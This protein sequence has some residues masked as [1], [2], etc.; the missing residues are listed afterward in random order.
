MSSPTFAVPPAPG[1]DNVSPVTASQDPASHLTHAALNGTT[2][3]PVAGDSFGAAYVTKAYELLARQPLREAL[4]F[5]QFATVRLANQTHRGAVVQVSLVPDLDDDPATTLL[6]EDYDVLPTPLKSR[7]GETRLKEYG[8]VITTTD[9][10]SA[11][12]MIPVDP[13]AAERLGRNAGAV[14]DRLAL[15]ALTGPAV[16]S[17]APTAASALTAPEEVAN[18]AG[19][20]TET[21]IKVSETFQASNVMPFSGGYYAAIISP[22]MASA[23]RKEAAAVGWRYWQAE[24]GNAPGGEIGTGGISTY[25]GFRFFVSNRVTDDAIFFGQ[26]ALLKTFPAA[27]GFGPYPQVVVSPIV[28]RLRRF[29]S[30]GWKW[31]GGYERFVHEAVL[32]G[33]GFG[34]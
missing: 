13:I 34:A 16:L 8:K 11:T 32:V 25:E 17:A 2:G 28:D 27:P 4:I 21:L 33:T 22:A 5:D 10:L 19:K 26:D 3:L 23:I 14:L 12:S 30:I 9:L 6:Q 18:V 1:S 20:P 29:A 31:I 7:V 15:A 24:A